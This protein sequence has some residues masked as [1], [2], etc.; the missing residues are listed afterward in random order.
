MFADGAEEVSHTFFFDEEFHVPW[1]LFVHDIEEVVAGSHG[2]VF[3]H[4]SELRIGDSTGRRC[5]D[6][7]FIGFSIFEG[8]K[9]IA[10]D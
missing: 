6:V 10:S 3:E 4:L 2:S 7:E 1:S 9:L 5:L 8:I